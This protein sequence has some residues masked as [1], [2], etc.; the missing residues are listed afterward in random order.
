M[1]LNIW[2]YTLNR[3]KA[4]GTWKSPLWKGKSSEPNGQP[5]LLLGSCKTL[6]SCKVPTSRFCHM[7]P[8]WQSSFCEG[9]FIFELLQKS[10]C[11]LCHHD[12]LACCD[13]SL[14]ND[15]FSLSVSIL[16][17]TG[18][19]LASPLST[20][21]KRVKGQAISTDSHIWTAYRCGSGV[22]TAVKLDK[23]AMTTSNS[24]LSGGE[25]WHCRCRSL[26]HWIHQKKPWQR[27]LAEFNGFYTKVPWKVSSSI[28]L[29]PVSYE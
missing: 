20:I 8:G 21:C 10:C 15:L 12:T 19:G 5:F 13:K 17:V 22:F 3:W 9:L 27:T 23:T 7:V 2:Y 4:K 1:I 11:D 16:T 28:H 6:R 26:D 14:C 24:R 18:V 25:L 29:P